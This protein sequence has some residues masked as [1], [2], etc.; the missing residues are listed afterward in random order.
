MH[1]ALEHADPLTTEGKEIHIIPIPDGPLNMAWSPDSAW[2]VVG[3]KANHF[4]IVDAQAGTQV[5]THKE[6]DEV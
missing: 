1:S 3:N 5:K 6:S 2:I 4:A